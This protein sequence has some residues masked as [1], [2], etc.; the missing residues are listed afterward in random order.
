MQQAQ[1]TRSGEQD[2][3]ERM[4]T[5]VWAACAAVALATVAGGATAAPRKAG[6]SS[7][8]VKRGEYLV[9]IGGCNDCHTPWK[10]GPKGPEQD[11]SRMLSGHPE[12]IAIS[13]AP[14]QG[15]E[16]WMI[17]LSGSFTAWSGPWG[18]SFTANLTPDQETGIGRWTEQ[19]FIETMRT[20]RHEGRGRQILPP[21]P[22]FNYAK[23]TDED[24][25]ATFAYLRSIPA[26]KNRVPDP[27]PPAAAA[28]AA[29]APPS[30]P[31]SGTASGGAAAPS[32]MGSGGA[33][34]PSGSGPGGP[35][36]Q[37]K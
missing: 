32:G 23:M 28:Q 18:V 22:W 14:E 15:A 2:E 9:T 11:M 10:M 24:L 29:G 36:G 26:I 6:A 25:K 13:A 21:M 33:A 34:G 12:Q 17:N 19:N 3:E 37:A 5:F 31:A 35:A 20:G 1:Q 30:A 16:P 8:A 4:R 7:A 27:L